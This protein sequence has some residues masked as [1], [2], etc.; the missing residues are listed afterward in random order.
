[1]TSPAEEYT[2]VAAEPWT[3][4]H[5]FLFSFFLFPFVPSSNLFKRHRIIPA[6]GVNFFLIKVNCHLFLTLIFNT[7]RLVLVL[8][9]TH[10]GKCELNE[11]R[12]S[13]GPQ[14]SHQYFRYKSRDRAIDPCLTRG[15]IVII[16][17]EY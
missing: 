14:C 7:R 15:S 17:M 1:M 4:S 6:L 12:G 8:T 5:L 13:Y 2:F 3:T 10:T 11:Y 16:L 9:M